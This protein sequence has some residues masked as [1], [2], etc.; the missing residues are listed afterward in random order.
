MISVKVGQGFMEKIFA[1]FLPAAPFSWSTLR[2]SVQIALLVKVT[3]NKLITSS[4]S[5][6]SS[7]P[8]PH[9]AY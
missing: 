5:M 7:V 9:A 2:N 1:W 3:A 8:R 6:N 4:F